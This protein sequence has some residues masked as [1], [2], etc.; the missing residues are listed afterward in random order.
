MIGKIL[1]IKLPDCIEN[2]LCEK[3]SAH[4]SIK[5]FKT[6]LFYALA[7]CLSLSV[8]I[9]FEYFGL[10]SKLLNGAFAF[11]GF[12]LLLVLDKKTL[13]LAGFLTG[14]A[15]FWWL[16]MSFLFKDAT[17]FVFAA[18]L[19]AAAIYGAIF[20]VLFWFKNIFYRTAAMIFGFDALAPFGF[21]WFKPEVVLAPTCFGV[22]KQELFLVIAALIALLFLQKRFKILALLPLALSL[23]C[24]APLEPL[25]ANIALADTQIKQKDKWNPK[26]LKQNVGKI[27]ELINKAAQEKKDAIILPESAFAMLLNKESALLGALQDLSK[28]HKIVIITGGLF[29]DNGDFFNSTYIFSNGDVRVIN[30][31]FLVPF[32][33]E[34]PLPKF[35]AKHV[36]NVFFGGARDF[37]TAQEPT[38]YTLGGQRVRNAICYEATVEKMYKNSPPYMIVLSNN[39]WFYPSTQAVLQK[40]VMLFFARKYGVKIYH[41]ANMQG[42]GIIN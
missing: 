7:A 24:A 9:Y 26:L 34:I 17:V 31:V 2:D 38:D 39:A 28:W 1:P 15:W 30:K 36:N 32:G 20:Y 8:A 18:P 37:Q 23:N 41:S 6:R 21:E 13:F 3:I 12:A 25:K 40:Q 19:F 16:G 14:L 11:V 27:L 35:L 42:T 10:S 5:S 33:E 4:I 22:S 29:Y